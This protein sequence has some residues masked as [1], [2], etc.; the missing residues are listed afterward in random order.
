M[1]KTWSLAW[2]GL[3]AGL[4]PDLTGCGGGCVVGLYMTLAAPVAPYQ[5]GGE[6]A[7]L[8]PS[9]AFL[10]ATFAPNVQGQHTFAIP[11]APS[12]VGLTVTS[13]AM[14]GTGRLSGPTVAVVVP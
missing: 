1:G 8:D 10:R 3:T 2:D 5:L 4:A 12:L 6:Y 9:R 11:L 7:Y 13:Q 14:F